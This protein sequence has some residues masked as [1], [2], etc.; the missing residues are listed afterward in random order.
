MDDFA[1]RFVGPVRANGLAGDS[2]QDGFGA[3]NSR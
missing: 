2:S 3:V 1:K